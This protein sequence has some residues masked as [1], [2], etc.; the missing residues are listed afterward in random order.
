MIQ[1]SREEQTVIY[2]LL[3]IVLLPH[4]SRSIYLATYYAIA[5]APFYHATVSLY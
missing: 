4:I 3:G 2:I 1:I 5:I